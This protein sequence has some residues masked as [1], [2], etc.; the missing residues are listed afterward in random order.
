MKQVI[1]TLGAAD[2]EENVTKFT[3]HVVSTGVRTINLL[4]AIIRGCWLI[5]RDWVFTSLEKRSW[6]DPLPFEMIHYSKAV[7]VVLEFSKIDLLLLLKINCVYYIMEMK[8]S[9]YRS[10]VEIVRVLVPLTSRTFSFCVEQYMWK[11]EQPHLLK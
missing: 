9:C 3:T 1:K 10:T 2:F 4:R 7:K 11:V 5:G 6:Q 8:N